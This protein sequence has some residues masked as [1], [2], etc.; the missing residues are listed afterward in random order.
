MDD[1]LYLFLFMGGGMAKDGN[2]S[3]NPMFLFL[4]W[5]FFFPFVA[6]HVAYKSF[7]WSVGC[8]VVGLSIARSIWPFG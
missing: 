8:S 4:F 6:R 2:V 7:C 1:F 5:R 3:V